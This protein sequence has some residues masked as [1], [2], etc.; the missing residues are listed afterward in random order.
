MLFRSL[1]TGLQIFEYYDAPFTISDGVFGSCFY[2]TAGFHVFVSFIRFV[3]NHYA[4]T[5]YFGFESGIWYWHFVDVVWLFLFVTLYWWGG[6]S[7]DQKIYFFV[8]KEQ[9]FAQWAHNP[10]VAGSIPAV[11][12]DNDL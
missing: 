9:W 3:V 6:H 2:L 5:H 7:I 1:F 8:N 11:N 4:D 12:I 10:K